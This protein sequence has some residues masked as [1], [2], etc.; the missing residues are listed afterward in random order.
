[1]LFS[2]M[3][4][5]PVIAYPLAVACLLVACAY[6]Y[7][8]DMRIQV[9]KQAHVIREQEKKLQAQ[10]HSGQEQVND[11]LL[12]GGDVTDEAQLDPEQALYA[13]VCEYLLANRP[14]TN[15]NMKM[16]DL[17]RALHTNRTTLGYCIRKYSA[18]HVTTQQLVAR[19][20]LRYAEKLLTDEHNNMNVAEVA[21]AAGFNSRST[22]NRQFAQLYGSSPT[23]YRDMF[24]SHKDGVV[25]SKR[26]NTLEK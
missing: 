13:R 9:R 6:V 15:P 7:V 25:P 18:G 17:A 22:F 11:D 20:R 4:S 5:F 16:E 21:E 26:E 12:A 19:F 10:S 24:F 14:Y 23:D 3:S 8:Y 2:T 1:M